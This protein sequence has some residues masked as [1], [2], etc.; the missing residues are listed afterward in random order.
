M[1][2][3]YYS[4]EQLVEMLDES[5]REVCR[6]ILAD[7]RERFSKAQG[8]THNHQNWPGGYFDHVRECMNIAH[9]QYWALSAARPLPFTLSDALLIMFLHDIEKP[10]RYALNDAGELEIIPG[11]ESKEARQEFRDKKLA[12]YGLVLTPNQQNAMEFVEGEYK[13]YSSKRRMS[14]PLAAFCH[15]CDVVSA[16]IWFDCPR[17]EHDPWNI[18]E[19]IS[20]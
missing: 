18:A 5:V 8:A 14:G 15:I 11:L 3:N 12:E 7:N 16:R 13:C 17:L 9:L 1:I 10:W 19:R 20:K 4:L 2:P 6:R